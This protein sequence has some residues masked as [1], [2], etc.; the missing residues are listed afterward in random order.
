MKTYYKAKFPHIHP[1]GAAFFITFRLHGSLPKS[2]LD[3]LILDYNENK[4]EL[5]NIKDE[6]ERNLK[7]FNLRKQTFAKYDDLLDKIDTGPHYLKDESIAGIIKEQL[8]RFDGALYDLIAY[9]I[10]SNHVHILID[11]RLNIEHM[12]GPDDFFEENTEVSN[13][14]KRIKGASSRYANKKMGK[15]GR[16]WEKESYDMYIRNEKMLNNVIGYILNNPVKA[17]ICNDWTSYPGNYLMP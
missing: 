14:M 8:H 11:T 12:M 6:H 15:Q 4:E 1:K 2:K 13:I 7:I 10:M 16:F 3:S 5:L 9:S 17:K